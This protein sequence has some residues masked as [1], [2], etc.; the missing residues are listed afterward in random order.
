M[1]EKQMRTKSAKNFNNSDGS[2]TNTMMILN[3]MATKTKPKIILR[4]ARHWWKECAFE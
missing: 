4:W 2:K 1:K 3:C